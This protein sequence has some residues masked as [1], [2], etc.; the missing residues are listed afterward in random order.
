[1][2]HFLWFLRAGTA[3]DEYGDSQLA[4]LMWLVLGNENSW[5]REGLLTVGQ[6]SPILW[7]FVEEPSLSG[8]K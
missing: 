5:V 7:P 4:R 1:M 6:L 2:R 3:T 8:R